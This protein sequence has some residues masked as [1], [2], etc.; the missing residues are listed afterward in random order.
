MLIKDKLMKTVLVTGA[1]GFLGSSIVKKLAI[2][3]KVIALVRKNSDTSRL[4]SIE[5]SKNIKII[6]LGDIFELF[7]NKI[8]CIIN[9][10][11]NYNL[12]SPNDKIYEDNY[13]FGKNLFDIATLNNIDLF[14][15]CSS[16][17]QLEKSRE[18]TY[19]LAKRRLSNYLKEHR[20]NTKVVDVVIGVLYGPG[21]NLDKFIPWII[22][23]NITGL[24]HIDLSSCLQKRVYSYISDASN[25]FYT[26][27]SEQEKLK[28]YQ[29]VN[30]GGNSVVSLKDV[31]LTIKRLLNST[32]TY[33]F[34]IKPTNTNEIFNPDSN[35]KD[36]KLL[37]WEPKITL[38]E[39][40]RR[41]I[42]EL[43]FLANLRSRT[44]LK[45]SNKTIL[46]TGANG[47]LGSGFVQILKY[48]SKSN[49]IISTTRSQLDVRNKS[50]FNQYDNLDIDII[51]HCAAIVNADYCEDNPDESNT[52]IVEGTKN[53]VAFAQRNKCL[54][55]YPQSFLIFGNENEEVDEESNA[56]PI[57]VYGQHKLKAENC[58]KESGVQ[59]LILR[60][61][62]F[63]GGYSKDKNFVGKIVPHMFR[64]SKSEIRTLQIG[65][66]I[67]Q[68]T[69]TI[70][71]AYNVLL[72]TENE[73]T[74][75]FNIASKESASFFD[76][77]EVINETLNL[78]LSLEKVSYLN[79]EK[80]ASAPRPKKLLLNT[81][82]LSKTGWNKQDYWDK[83][84]IKYLDNTFFN[85]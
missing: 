65:D 54:I 80:N 83:S 73:I 23:N 17:Y 70:D 21:D 24:N 22:Q 4:T 51:I 74:G 60:L 9:T 38:D 27:I 3:Y 68:P 78:D 42:S 16:F 84:L 59:Y 15:N 30:L 36:L 12:Q 34:G 48:L 7:E 69:Y 33:N 45:L 18:D 53:V 35:Y 6:K 58:I 79:V 57:S 44:Q 85:L 67:W 82:L 13:K 81:K 39:G 76:V 40:L 63:F 62:G 8:D 55:I 49:I 50:H 29:Q 1:S 25:A 2:S 32:I 41:T 5:Y 77:C 19:S 37:G 46:I 31:L 56:V 71:I 66:R 64:I 28:G 43:Q 61:G 14:V 52:T 20:K 72:L 11:G 75:M 26:I 47:M 10:V